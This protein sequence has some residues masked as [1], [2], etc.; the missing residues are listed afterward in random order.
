MTAPEV[1]V[2]GD[3]NPD[4][5]L[6]GD[7][8]PRFGQAE[9]ILDGALLTMG[10]SACILA[11]GLARLGVDVAL[12]GV[13]GA[14]LFGDYVRSF[15]TDAGVNTTGLRTHESLPTGVT[16]VLGGGDRAILTFPGTIPTL[17]ADDV[18]LELVWS[19]R[20]LHVAA[21]F[22]Q[23]ALA[24]GLPQLLATAREAGATTS[25][26]TN[27]D[28]S[29]RWTGVAQLLPHVDLVFPNLVELF[30]LAGTGGDPADP[31]AQDAAAAR[32]GS[33]GT[34][35]VAVKAGADGGMV[36]TPGGQRF[37]SPGLVV[38]VVDTTGAGDSFD[39]GY[40][41]AL[42]EGATPQQC[43]DRAVI[44][45]SLSTRG[46]GGTTAQPSRDEVASFTLSGR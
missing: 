24:P 26:D 33:A 39:A 34:T 30:A 42:L 2:L 41:S 8:V 28:P 1:V 11:C 7:V 13:V 27:W 17:T 25:L 6:T 4:L 45:G 23:P 46:A 3:A 10:G 31:R 36:W 35:T 29:D 21:Y 44:C 18:D 22:M 14:D 16:V 37:T 43:L 32:L 40:L 5:V 15:L 12:V 9:Q 38:D 19:A 20:H